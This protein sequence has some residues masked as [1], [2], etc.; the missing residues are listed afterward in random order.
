MELQGVARPKPNCLTCGK[1]VENEYGR[2]TPGCTC[3]TSCDLIQRCCNVCGGPWP[4]HW[5]ETPEGMRRMHADCAAN[6][7]KQ[8]PKG[9]D[10]DPSV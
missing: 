4:S 2:Y 1:P 7:H 6:W 5:V 10:D 3:S 8:H 9:Y